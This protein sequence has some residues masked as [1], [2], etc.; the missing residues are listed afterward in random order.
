MRVVCPHC[1]AAYQLEGVD[2]GTILVCHRC[3]T[4]FAFGQPP[5]DTEACAVTPPEEPED[6]DIL[7]LFAIN[8]APG[9]PQLDEGVEQ[10]SEEISD[11]DETVDIEPEFEAEPEAGAETASIPPTGETDKII[12]TETLSTDQI[13]PSSAAEKNDQETADPAASTGIDEDKPLPPP[14][15]TRARIMPWLLTIILLIAAAGFWLKHDAWLDD[16]WLR[17]VLINVGL[18][19]AVRDKDWYIQPDSVHAQWIKRDNG[20]Q[21]LVIEG[22]V[23]SLLQCEL[24]PPAIRFSIF[25]KDAPEHLLL[26]RELVISQPPLM[27]AIRH[28]P[29]IVQPE[30][31]VPVPALGDRGFVLVLEGLPKNAGDFTLAPVSRGGV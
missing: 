31:H 24:A 20:S 12:P 2:E 5:D 13:E 1:Q 17:S 23:K 3:G 4:E 16:P 30:D 10:P 19:V 25:A 11:T 8:P 27:V 21:V 29:Y 26:E 15:R 18:P 6:K 7:P 22:R 9:E 14:P 28:A